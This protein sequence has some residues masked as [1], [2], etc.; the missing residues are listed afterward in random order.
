MPPTTEQ[1]GRCEATFKSF[2]GWPEVDWAAVADDGYEAIPENA[3]TYLE[4]HRR[5]TRRRSTPSASVPAVRGDHR[6]RE[7]VRVARRSVS[8]LIAT[9]TIH[10]LIES[11][12]CDQVCS[13][14][15]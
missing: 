6:R 4:V 13:E 9:E 2:D 5:R 3:R 14:F 7:P 8:S 15:Q 1:W 11:L 10:T 12:S